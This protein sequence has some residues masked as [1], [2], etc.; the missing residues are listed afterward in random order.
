[1]KR[2]KFDHSFEGLWWHINYSGHFFL[3]RRKVQC[4]LFLH[5]LGFTLGWFRILSFRRLRVFFCFSLFASFFLII[6]FLKSRKYFY[7]RSLIKRILILQGVVSYR[8]SCII[9]HKKVLKGHQFPEQVAHLNKSLYTLSEESI[10]V[11]LNHRKIQ[12]VKKFPN[13]PT[14]LTSLAKNVTIWRLYSIYKPIW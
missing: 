5:I 14:N 6:N 3:F 2:F 12:K 4:N 9:L 10:P 11:M 8:Y 7:N 1:M 13:I